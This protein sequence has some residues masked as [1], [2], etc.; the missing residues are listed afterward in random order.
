MWER[1]LLEMIFLNGQKWLLH[2]VKAM[3]NSNS[4]MKMVNGTLP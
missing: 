3:Q 1:I 4:V 2:P